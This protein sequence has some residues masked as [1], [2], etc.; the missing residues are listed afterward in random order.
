MSTMSTFDRIKSYY[1]AKEPL[2]IIGPPGI[3]KS[4]MIQQIAAQED[5]ECQDVRLSLMDPVDLRGLPFIERSQKL[6]E[7][8][9]PDFIRSEGRGILLWDEINLAPIAVQNT[10]M[11]VLTEY[12]VGPHTLS[13]DIWQV[14]CGNKP[15][16]RAHVNPISAPLLNRFNILEIEAPNKDEWTDYAVKQRFSEDVISFIN[17][18]SGLLYQAPDSEFENFPTPR[19]WERVSRLLD[20][21]MEDLLF[22]TGAVGKG[23]AVEFLGF[24]KQRAVLPDLDK[25]INGEETFNFR[26]HEIS[27]S[28]AAVTSLA[29]KVL[30]SDIDLDMLNKCSKV[31]QGIVPE[32]GALFYTLLFRGDSRNR[33]LSQVMQSNAAQQWM[34]QHMALIQA[35]MEQ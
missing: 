30:D 32:I 26:E 9:A 20:N 2:L 12:R 8:A 15:E 14:A 29:M 16:H 17:F 28:Y 22:L 5:I 27:I 31:V 24:R 33:A 25:L 19:G 21:G 7:W 18:R 23:A 1:D 35:A 10:A 4:Q 6:V 3:G 34:S 11:Q 13:R